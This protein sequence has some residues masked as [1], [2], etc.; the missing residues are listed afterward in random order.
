[1]VRL[2]LPPR[3]GDALVVAQFDGAV[4]YRVD[5]ISTVLRLLPVEVEFNRRNSVFVQR[6]EIPPQRCKRTILL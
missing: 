2:G 5:R 1:M 3:T 6:A 4:G